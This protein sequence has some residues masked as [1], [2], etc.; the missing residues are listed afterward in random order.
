[1]A[2]NVT[3]PNKGG[4]YNNIGYFIIEPPTPNIPDKNEPMNPIANK[5]K[6]N[7]TSIFTPSLYKESEYSI[8]RSMLFEYKNIKYRLLFF[9]LVLCVHLILPMLECR[10]RLLYQ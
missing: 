9:V 2:V 4:I 1:C 7:V 10:L 3:R 8:T 6:K 5:T